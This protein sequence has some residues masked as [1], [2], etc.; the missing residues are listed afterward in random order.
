MVVMVAT[1]VA[2][3][4]VAFCMMSLDMDQREGLAWCRVV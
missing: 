3:V 1:T 4:V 2:T